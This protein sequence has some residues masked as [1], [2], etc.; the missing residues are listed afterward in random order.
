MSINPYE[1]DKNLSMRHIFILLLLVIGNSCTHREE[2]GPAPISL[3]SQGYVE[4]NVTDIGGIYPIY[5]VAHKAW[6]DKEI[7]QVEFK[8]DNSLVYKFNEENKNTLKPLPNNV[9]SIQQNNFTL[10]ESTVA[11]TCKLLLDLDAYRKELHIYEETSYAVG[12]QLYVNGVPIKNQ[13]GKAILAFHITPAMISI[14]KT[15]DTIKVENQEDF[16]IDIPYEL[17]FANPYTIKLVPSFDSK[18]VEEYNKIHKTSHPAFNPQEI[19]VLS[20]DQL[21]IDRDRKKGLISFIAKKD[22]LM[23]GITVLPITI[24]EIHSSSY[25]DKPEPRILINPQQQVYYCIFINS[26]KTD[27]VDSTNNP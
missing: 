8:I 18:W 16:L 19:S 9:F 25:I 7:S 4:I 10:Q 26:P 6:R 12:I 2:I 22:G 17:N 20:Q 21:V 3:D 27:E 13:E 11:C 24:S 5:L 23:P 1:I 14:V 15:N